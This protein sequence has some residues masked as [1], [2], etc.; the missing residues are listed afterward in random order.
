MHPLIPINV[1]LLALS[2]VMALVGFQ[3]TVRNNSCFTNK[4]ICHT[5]RTSFLTRFLFLDHQG[6]LFNLGTV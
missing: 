4:F 2:L 6:G 5:L 3:Q 1:S